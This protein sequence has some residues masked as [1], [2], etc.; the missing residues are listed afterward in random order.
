MLS[1]SF[2]LSLVCLGSPVT[3][4]VS[5]D[6]HFTQCGG[7]FDTE[8]NKRGIAQ[9]NTLEGEQYPSPR[10]GSVK[11]IQGVIIPGDLVD[12]GCNPSTATE[13]G[14]AEQLGNY[15]KAFGVHPGEGLVKCVTRSNDKAKKEQYSIFSIFSHSFNVD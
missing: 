4:I 3:F 15:T 8:K 6:T 7:V 14:C 13:S 10:G 5:P 2:L 1:A 9:M 12:D 11:Q